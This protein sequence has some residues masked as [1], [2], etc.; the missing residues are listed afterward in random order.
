MVGC[1]QQLRPSS[2]L[3]MTPRHWAVTKAWRPWTHGNAAT[4]RAGFRGG[5]R[6][7]A[8]GGPKPVSQNPV[9]R[10][11]PQTGKPVYI[12]TPLFYVN[13]DPHIGHLYSVLVGD[14][15]ARWYQLHGATTYLLVGTDEHGLKVQQS[16]AAQ[17]S[18]SGQ[19]S[20]RWQL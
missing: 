3:K 19:I 10:N 15:M 16:A 1:V 13:G 9:F 20:P 6:H 8:D 7:N 2:V 5:G 17:V 4:P 12:T 14:A 18:T 11:K